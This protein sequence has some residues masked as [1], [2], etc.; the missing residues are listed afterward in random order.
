VKRVLISTLKPS[1]NYGQILQAYASQEFFRSKGYE[2]F[3]F[4]HTKLTTKLILRKILEKIIFFGDIKDIKKNAKKSKNFESFI[5]L[6][7]NKLNGK[8]IEKCIKNNNID[9]LAIGSDQ[10]WRKEYVSDYPYYYFPSEKICKTI[11]SI[12]ASTGKEIN[13]NDSFYKKHL[14]KLMNLDLITCREDLFSELITKNFNLKSFHICDPTLLLDVHHYEKLSK[15][16]R[17]YNYLSQKKY[18][19]LYGLD[20]NIDNET[21][22][23]LSKIS[24]LDIIEVNHYED[25]IEN[26]L[27]KFQFASYIITDS[28][29]G[30]QFSCI[31]N[32][33][34]IVRKN[35]KRGSLRFDS[36]LR[37]IK[38]E[39]QFYIQ[40]DELKSIINSKKSISYE[41]EL[42]EFVTFSKNI[43]TK[44][45]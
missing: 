44:A 6:K 11:I 2:S 9:V 24:N 40:P 31:F 22:N 13:I 27:A 12:A 7:L 16:S 29:H 26:F 21:R 43:L 17:I 10:V 18:I 42:N 37:K 34:F 19:L 20:L 38:C 35:P 15:A 14:P 30:L 4:I 28:F 3:I 25:N 32:K 1:N 41:N 39:N 23:I 8:K 33:Q 5:D 36:F 45:I